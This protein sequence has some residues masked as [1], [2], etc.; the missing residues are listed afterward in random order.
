MSTLGQAGLLGAGGALEVTQL[1]VLGELVDINAN[2]PPVG[3]QA[4]AGSSPVTLS[5][6]Q[7]A[8][9]GSLTETAPATDTASS[10]LNGR[11]QRVSQR[12]TDLIA[13]LPASIGQKAD[14]GSLG[15]ALSTEDVQLL[16]DLQTLLG[17]LNDSAPAT[18]TD[19]ASLNG[20]L[21]RV[22]QNITSL[23]AQQ[24]PQLGSLTETAPG[25]D[26]ASSGLNGRLQRL[27]QLMSLLKLQ[28]PASLGATTSANSLSVTLASDQA[29][30]PAAMS[31]GTQV[32][33]TVAGTAAT[34][35]AP[36]SAIGFILQGASANGAALRW[37]CGST[38]SSS[39][40]MRLEP[41]QDSG[42][43]P[44]SGDISIISESGTN[45]Y[46]VQ[47]IGF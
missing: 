39:V 46:E 16:V 24:S 20:R 6:E 14:A 13:L 18:D 19:P 7:Q 32:T 45:E 2:T 4:N 25:T 3:Q 17:L 23:S 30:K 15:V 10:G 9:L 34:L 42:Y 40:G 22:A 12:L 1:Q 28:L 27:A 38:A 5:T 21:Q 33:A 41:G 31:V 35:L 44:C 47:W 37:R 36:A 8:Q 29:V 11:L 43:V 26:T